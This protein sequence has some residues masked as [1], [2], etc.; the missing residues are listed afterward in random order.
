VGLVGYG[1]IGRLVGRFLVAFGAR[2]LAYDPHLSDDG[3]EPPVEPVADLAELL[4]ASQ[5]VSLHARLTPE[6]RHLIGADEIARMPAGAVLVNTARGGLLDYDALCDALDAGHLAAA[7]VDVFPVEPLPADS[8]LFTTRGLVMTPHIAG[9]SRQ[10]A[11]RAAAICA[12]EVARWLADEPPAHC[13]N[14][15]VLRAR[16]LRGHGN[17]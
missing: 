6:T 10:V 12:G 14:P 8:R 13:A 3:F 7:G 17:R 1:A 4:G 16:H 11:G 15:D 9:C 5:V 2:V